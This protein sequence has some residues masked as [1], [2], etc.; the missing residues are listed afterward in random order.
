M[1]TYYAA[2]SLPVASLLIVLVT[3]PREATGIFITGIIGA[4]I[5]SLCIAVA[6]L[7]ERMLLRSTTY[8]ITSEYISVE[9]G[10]SI[11]GRSGRHIQI[12]HICG[13]ATSASFT[14][15][16]LGL[17]DLTMV[18][19][20]GAAITFSDIPET[21]MDDAKNIIWQLTKPNPLPTTV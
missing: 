5:L 14:Q 3:T 20:G 4:G 7:Y 12:M 11:L 2:F 15:R 17:G 19:A 8:S 13:V 21:D 16:C 1:W 18:A 9:A 10:L 6:L